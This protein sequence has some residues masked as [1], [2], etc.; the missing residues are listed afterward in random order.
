[1]N[2]D[3]L[4]SIPVN[5][6]FFRWQRYDENWL[7]SSMQYSIRNAP[8]EGMGQKPLSV[9]SN[10]NCIATFFICSI[11]DFFWRMAH[12][13]EDFGYEFKARGADLSRCFFTKSLQLYFHR[14]NHLFMLLFVEFLRPGHINFCVSRKRFNYVQND[15][16]C[17]MLFCHIDSI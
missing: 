3:L 6:A 1:M 2:S 12:R 15:N 14:F 9:G 8:K 10:D 11:Q 4:D 7:S 5:S 17:I 16:S 13:N